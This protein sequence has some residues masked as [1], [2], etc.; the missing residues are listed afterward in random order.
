MQFKKGVPEAKPVLLEPYC[1]LK[2]TIPEYYMGDVISGINTK[3]GRILS[4]ESPSHSVCIIEAQVP[5]AELYKYATDLRSATQGRGSYT[6]NFSHYEEVP[7][8][9][10]E[11]IVAERN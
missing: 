3:R 5:Q 2:I 7:A 11:K 8:K 1:N 4:T 10:S 9:I 6:M